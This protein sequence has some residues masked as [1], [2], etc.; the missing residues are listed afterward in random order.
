MENAS[1][2]ASPKNEEHKYGSGQSYLY[3]YTY[4]DFWI[5]CVRA[6]DHISDSCSIG[7]IKLELMT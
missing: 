7:Y 2:Y 6:S 4:Q 3:G 5:E 1:K